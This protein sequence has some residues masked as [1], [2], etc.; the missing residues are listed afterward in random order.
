MD[1]DIFVV[2]YYTINTNNKHISNLDGCL[3]A[4]PSRTTDIYCTTYC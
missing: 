2:Q 1:N 3:L 4:L